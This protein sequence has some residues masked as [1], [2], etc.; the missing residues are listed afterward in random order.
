M[1]LFLL[2]FVFVFLCIPGFLFSQELVV[3]PYGVS[4]AAVKADTAGNP[5]YLGIRDIRFTGLKNVGVGT[6]VYLI[7]TNEDTSLTSPSLPL[8]SV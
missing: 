6:K 2:L 1:K 7:G 4:P 8:R 5:T 3:K